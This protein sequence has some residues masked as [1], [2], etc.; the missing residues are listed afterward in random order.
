MKKKDVNREAVSKRKASFP[1]IG[2]YDVPASHFLKILCGVDMVIAPPI[3]RKTLELGTTHSPDLACIPFKYN[4]GNFIEALDS[5]VE[6][7]IQT[8]GKCRLGYY[9]EVQEQILRD[10]G[11]Q[12]EFHTTKMVG[13]SPIDLYRVFKNMNPELT[14]LKAAKALLTGACLVRAIDEINAYIRLNRCFE[15]VK[16]S[17]EQLKTEYLSILD[18]SGTISEIKKIKRAY[19]EKFQSLETRKTSTPLKVGIVGE[20]FIVQEA[21]SN[22]DLEKELSA[23]GIQVIRELT[24][25][26]VLFSP[27]K[28]NDKSILKRA[29]PYL[30]YTI[31]ADASDSV[32]MSHSYAKQGCDGIIHL[33]P[34]GC[35]P[36]VNSIP[37]VKKIGSDF[38]IPV[39]FICFDAHTSETGLRTRLEAFHDMLIMRREK[40]G[41]SA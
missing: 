13:V 6:I 35:V 14:V 11:Y 34:F 39:L 31:G 22:Y 16:G 21:F 5:G 15:T 12:F 8:G 24:M 2:D 40:V 3:T 32:A 4:L 41:K 30:K 10:L 20:I 33:R 27:W 1:H 26:Y 29:G 37:M 9:G 28:H 36:E 25:S 23:M 19:M 38:N 18:T 7:L 17:F